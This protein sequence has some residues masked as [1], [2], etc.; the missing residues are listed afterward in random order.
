[1][2]SSKFGFKLKSFDFYFEIIQLTFFFIG[3]YLKWASLVV[4]VIQNAST[5][6]LLRY[7]R[8]VPG[9][10]FFS[11]TAIVCQ[12]II[13]MVVAAVLLYAESFDFNDFKNAI[14]QQ[15]INNKVDSIKTGVPALLFTIQTNLVYLAISN[16]DAAVFQVT[17]QIKILTTALFTVVLLNRSL[18]FLQWISLIIL[19]AGVSI[20]QIQNVNGSN[21]NNDDHKNAIFGLLCVLMACTLSGLAGVY[22]EKILKNSKV[23]IWVR[24]IQLGV[25]GTFFALMTVFFSDFDNVKEKGFFFGYN[26]LVWINIIIQSAGGLLVA[27]VIK[28]AD[29]ILK[30]FAT[31]IAIIV[32]CLA[33]VYLF[34]TV[35]DSVF[36]FGTL[37]VVLSVVLYSYVPSNVN[38]TST[39]SSQDDSRRLLSETHELI[40][41][42]LDNLINNNDSNNNITIEM[43]A[44]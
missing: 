17:F 2:A 21:S 13:K 42:K 31:S 28:Y 25:F 34:S 18:R 4:L 5:I 9:D 32:S 30:G 11:T 10:M 23:S 26:S 39:T 1:M 43:Q 19:C 12:E 6:L 29:N 20:I 44:K 35:I 40:K 27:V 41:Y 37:L 16:L 22:F 14:N 36:A 38:S 7:V 3:N 8:T 24:N 15:I 33:S